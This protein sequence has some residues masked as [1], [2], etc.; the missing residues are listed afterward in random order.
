M[1][2]HASYDAKYTCVSQLA[3]DVVVYCPVMQECAKQFDSTDPEA[4]AECVRLIAAREK[5]FGASDKEGGGGGRYTMDVTSVSIN[6][7]ALRPH[8]MQCMLCHLESNQSPTL[9]LYLLSSAL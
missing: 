6:G 9:F 1:I 8:N 7:G 5:E 3:I 4:S 2:A